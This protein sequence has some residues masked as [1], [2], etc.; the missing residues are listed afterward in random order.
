MIMAIKELKPARFDWSA[1]PRKVF[2]QHPRIRIVAQLRRAE[3]ELT[4]FL[5]EW[6]G[7]DIGQTKTGGRSWR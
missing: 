1:T 6:H 2:G 3:R 7:A 5:H 4:A